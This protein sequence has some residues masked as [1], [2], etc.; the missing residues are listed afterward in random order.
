[1]KIGMSSFCGSI[2]SHPQLP[3]ISRW[4]AFFKMATTLVEQLGLIS[5]LVG[6][7]SM[8]IA[9]SHLKG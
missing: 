2:D 6:D 3:E 9:M 1:M 5:H 8:T 4:R 7:T